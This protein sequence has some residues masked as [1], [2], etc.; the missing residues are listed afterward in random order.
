MKIEPC[1]QVFSGQ[2]TL[3]WCD[4]SGKMFETICD[5]SQGAIVG[6]PISLPHISARGEHLLPTGCIFIIVAEFR[7]QDKFADIRVLVNW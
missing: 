5:N 1:R 4:K 6:P 3:Y 2:M 7:V